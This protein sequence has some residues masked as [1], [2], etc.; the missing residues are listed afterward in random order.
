MFELSYGLFYKRHF[1]DM[2]DYFLLQRCFLLNIPV[3]DAHNT[4]CYK[5]IIRN[6]VMA[7]RHTRTVARDCHGRGRRE[8]YNIIIIY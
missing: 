6:T 2:A 1:H 3:M 5:I 7:R 8:Y 4:Y